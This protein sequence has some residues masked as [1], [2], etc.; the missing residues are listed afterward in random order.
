ML[1]ADWERLGAC[2]AYRPIN[3]EDNLIY[4]F[5]GHCRPPCTHHPPSAAHTSGLP[6]SH[7][8]PGLVTIMVKWW[9][10]ESR[11]GCH[12][13][14]YPN[15]LNAKCSPPYK[16]TYTLHSNRHSLSFIGQVGGILWQEHFCGFWSVLQIARLIRRITWDCS[17]LLTSCVPCPPTPDVARSRLDA[18]RSEI[19]FA[20]GRDGH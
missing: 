11:G 14:I 6:L 1:R 20:G 10:E 2:M 12:N 8:Y 19:A 5:I 4:F 18:D 15:P 17:V 9:G 16:L 7:K 3:N 13:H